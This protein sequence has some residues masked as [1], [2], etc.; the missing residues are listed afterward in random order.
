MLFANNI[1]L[2]NETCGGVK[3]RLK[4]WRLVQK[5]KGFGLNGTKT[6]YLE[7][8]FSD[9]KHEAKEEVKIDA[10]VTPKK[11]SFKYFGSRIQGQWE[12]DDNVAHHI[13]AGWVK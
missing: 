3:D 13:G 12:I 4:V 10:Q 1:L 8:K 2:I 6:E 5:S 9:V 7:F 11:G